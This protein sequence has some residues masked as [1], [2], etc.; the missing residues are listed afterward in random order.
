MDRA[1]IALPIERFNSNAVR[2]PGLDGAVIG[3]QIY[4]LAANGGLS[5]SYLDCYRRLS[6][7]SG[8]LDL[9][10]GYCRSY[11]EDTHR[12]EPAL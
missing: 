12:S 8:G 11:V 4:V 3:G 5:L 10:S 9:R 7:A 2:F 6:R 1:F